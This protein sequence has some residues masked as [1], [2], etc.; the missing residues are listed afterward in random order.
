MAGFNML[1]RA[2]LDLVGWQIKA[3][4]VGRTDSGTQIDL[5]MGGDRFNPNKFSLSEKG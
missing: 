3:A 2:R 1:G 5:W 4:T